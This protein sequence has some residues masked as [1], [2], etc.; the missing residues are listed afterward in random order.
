MIEAVA[1]AIDVLEVFSGPDG[2]S[3]GQ[4]S[5]RVGLNRSRT[6]R[7]LHTLVDRG[8]VERNEDGTSYRLGIRIF[9][10]AANVRRD[11]KD[12]ARPV[13]EELRRRF[14]ETVNLSVL[15]EGHALYLEIVENS[16]PVRMSAT[17][18]CRMPAHRTSLGKAMLAWKIDADPF[19]MNSGPLARESRHRVQKLRKEL[20]EIRQRRYAIDNEENEPGVAC[21]GA[22]ILDAQGQP[23]AAMSVS[24]PARRILANEKKI[25]EA[26]I[27]GCAKVSRGLGHAGSSSKRSAA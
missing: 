18:G 16:R 1:K 15:E 25:A 21:I 23:V 9:E 11:L 8:Y 24:G 17:V 2:L 6:F 3:L 20:E 5:E 7:L 14:N 22:P 4:I 12:V 10:R 13:M 27:S 26:V 19:C